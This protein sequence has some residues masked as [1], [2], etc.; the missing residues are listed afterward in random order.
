VSST[1][2]F[3]ASEH[4]Y[5]NFLFARRPRP[6]IMEPLSFKS[7]IQEIQTELGQ[8]LMAFFRKHHGSQ[9]QADAMLA[10]QF[11]AFGGA[12]K[13]PTDIR[14]LM[15]AISV[16]WLQYAKVY[17]NDPSTSLPRVKNVLQLL[18]AGAHE[19]AGSF[20][21]RPAVPSVSYRSQKYLFIIFKVF[22]V[23]FSTFCGLFC[24]L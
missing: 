23:I 9:P 22:H 3:T 17:T 13:T 4:T 8:I 12:Y 18:H 10:S 11:T 1:D 20:S 15:R 16:N 24:S 7:Y 19:S 6:E 2:H 21:A 5:S 14:F